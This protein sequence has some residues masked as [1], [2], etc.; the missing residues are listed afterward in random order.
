MQAMKQIVDAERL[1]S[2]MNM[3]EDMRHTKV[4]II[5]LPVAEESSAG[6]NQGVNLAALEKA[7]GSLHD[8]ADPELIPKEKNAW[9][10]GRPACTKRTPMA[11][12]SSL[13]VVKRESRRVSPL[14]KPCNNGRSLR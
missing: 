1:T 4:E 14:A 10:A 6:I 9:Q 11:E 12:E 8:Y 7:Y 3:P 2:F 5:V 13:R